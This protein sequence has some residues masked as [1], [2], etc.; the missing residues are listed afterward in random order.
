[1]MPILSAKIIP[2]TIMEKIKKSTW[3]IPSIMLY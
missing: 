1:M 3:L 2:V